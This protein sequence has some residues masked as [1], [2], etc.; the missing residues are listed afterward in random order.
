MHQ[1]TADK[2]SLQVVT[3]KWFKSK[4]FLNHPFKVIKRRQTQPEE[5]ANLSQK[6]TEACNAG[7]CPKKR[8][9]HE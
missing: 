7:K 6:Y 2:C 1:G 4:Q 9:D 5:F 8:K 3:N